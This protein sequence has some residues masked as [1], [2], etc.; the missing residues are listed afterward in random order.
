[1]AKRLVKSFSVSGETKHFWGVM[2]R[3]GKLRSNEWLSSENQRL[4]FYPVSD[5][6]GRDDFDEGNLPPVIEWEV[7]LHI[8]QPSS[9]IRPY[10]GLIASEVAPRVVQIDGLDG[11]MP[12]TFV[13]RLHIGPA[14]EEFCQWIFEE[15]NRAEMRLIP[16][17][18]VAQFEQ[19]ART[20]QAEGNWAEKVEQL[21]QT[22]DQK[23]GP[24]LLT[25]EPFLFPHTINITWGYIQNFLDNKSRELHDIL[26]GAVSIREAVNKSTLPKVPDVPTIAFIQRQRLVVTPDYLPCKLY[27]TVYYPS[28]RQSLEPKEAGMLF[29]HGDI[30][31]TLIE[32]AVFDER[33]QPLWEELK[34]FL[35]RLAPPQ[36]KVV[37]LVA[38]VKE[39]LL[40][41]KLS[42]PPALANGEEWDVTEDEARDR[43]RRAKF[44]LPTIDRMLKL[45]KTIIET[46][47]D[48][49]ALPSQ[50]ERDE[51]DK[52]RY[53]LKKAN[54]LPP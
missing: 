7:M 26:N 52:D 49:A 39:L 28:V 23:G 9:Q 37:Y 5:A 17:N 41:N 19:L 1:M 10:A 24:S 21:L 18:G 36:Q 35:E 33:L 53:N 44:R 45:R 14:F 2:K 54:L 51:Y 46:G 27:I 4:I 40:E 25:N 42:E 48:R 15:T 34:H 43:L 3:L 38:P 11:Y 13:D 30:N 8:D 6:M 50:E 29:L 47:V 31:Y 32:M 16:Q 20:E 22:M 12:H